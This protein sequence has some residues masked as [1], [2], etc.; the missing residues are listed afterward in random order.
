MK[1][2][3]S[4][5]TWGILIL[6]AVLSTGCSYNIPK[7]GVSVENVNNLKSIKTKINVG[8]FTTKEKGKNSIMCRGAGNV[9]T[10]DN[11]PFEQYIKS[12]LISELKLAGKFN[13]NSNITIS[14]HL[15]EVDFNSNIGTANWVFKLNA[16]SSNSK[17]I[18]VNTIYEFEGSFVADKAC[19][20]VA[21][22][23]IPAV[24]KLINDL[25]SHKDFNNFITRN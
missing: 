9:G 20:E 1:Y 11:T 19:S 10:P 14:G 5:K 15:D 13:E 22:A 24:Q 6:V 12:A 18:V 2:K 17:S 7:Y 8:E 25:V 21:Q 4:I 3:T 16:T 23:F